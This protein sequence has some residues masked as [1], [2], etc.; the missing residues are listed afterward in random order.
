MA[1]KH[2][3]DKQI[4]DQIPAARA[5]ARKSL[6]RRPHARDAHYDAAT[7]TLHV[8]LTNGGGFSLP[9]AMVSELQNAP[10]HVIAEV[11]VGP[12]GVGLHWEE[13]DVDLSVARLAE[14]VLGRGTLLRAAG[15]SGGSVRSEAKA[16]A[17]RLNGLKGGRPRAAKLVRGSSKRGG[18]KR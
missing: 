7:R 17:A 10:K 6:E 4:L 13:L 11:K 5:R 1:K 14:L 9:I 18:S 8:R 2:V 15:A 12:A 3:S 16:E